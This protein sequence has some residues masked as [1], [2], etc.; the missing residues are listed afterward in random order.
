MET[1]YLYWQWKSTIIDFSKI[2]DEYPNGTINFSK[3]KKK[4]EYI[5]KYLPLPDVEI[6]KWYNGG[7]S[8]EYNDALFYAEEYGLIEFTDIEE[9]EDD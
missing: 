6:H 1:K 9:K 5:F 8:S 2:P 4:K 7:W 3:K